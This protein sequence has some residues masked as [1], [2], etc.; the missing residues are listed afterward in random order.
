VPGKNSERGIFTK[1]PTQAAVRPRPRRRSDSLSCEYY[2]ADRAARWVKERLTSRDVRR[3]HGSH[4]WSLLTERCSPRE[5]A[6]HSKFDR[7]HPGRDCRILKRT[8]P[9]A[10]STASKPLRLH[11]YLVELP[12][13]VANRV[14]RYAECSQTDLGSVA[15]WRSRSKSRRRGNNKPQTTG[16]MNKGHQS[17]SRLPDVVEGAWGR[18][19]RRYLVE[20]GGRL[21]SRLDVA[22]ERARARAVIQAALVE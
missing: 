20:E 3:Q 6:R 5:G 18:S 19:S 17:M 2:V 8:V 7:E 15:K 9:L 16:G 4:S 10:F 11:S 22:G 21:A 12:S 1:R 13:S 14:A